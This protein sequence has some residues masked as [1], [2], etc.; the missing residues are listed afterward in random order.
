MT[1]SIVACSADRRQWGVAAAS[2]YLAV[3]GAVPAAQAGVG[4]LATQ[5]LANLAF[6]PQGLALLRVGLSASATLAALIASDE[7]RGDRQVGVVDAE[8]GAAT[9]TGPACSAWA[10]GVTG[11]G[12]AI[13]GNLLTGPTVIGQMERVFVAA[14]PDA[15]LARRLYTALVAGDAAGGDR[16][17]RQSGC[18]LVVDVD[19]GRGVG[20]DVIHDLRVDDHRDPIVELGR[21]LELGELYFGR[22][23]PDAVLPLE[24]A[25][26]DEVGRR[27]ALLGHASLAGWADLE[28][29]ENRLVSD[30]LDPVVLAKLRE[31]TPQITA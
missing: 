5:S 7:G 16:R 14:G 11:A 12:Y 6:R 1:F 9:Y 22:P 8:A 3:G 23:D 19:R 31:A 26:A 17:G 24:G 4:A 13:Q 25:L 18:L 27:V 29:L 10:G 30:G 21:L 28:N 15:P 2:R 20:A